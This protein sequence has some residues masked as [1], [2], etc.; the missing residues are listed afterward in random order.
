MWIAT[1][2]CIVRRILVRRSFQGK[3]EADSL[4]SEAADLWGRPE[5]G[6]AHCIVFGCEGRRSR[7]PR[8]IYIF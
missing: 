2:W 1:H 7:H 4:H 3:G 6:R 8:H 5:L